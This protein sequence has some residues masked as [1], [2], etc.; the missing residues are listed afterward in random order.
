MEN[1]KVIEKEDNS[2]V[3]YVDASNLTPEEVLAH[4]EGQMADMNI[5]NQQRIVFT[6]DGETFEDVVEKL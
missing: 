2:D 4:I 3:Q 6:N 5:N 1:I